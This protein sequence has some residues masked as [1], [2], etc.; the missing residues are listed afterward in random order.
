[1]TGVSTLAV[2]SYG[3]TALLYGAVTLWVLL[4]HRHRPT[5][6]MI[7]LV[8]AATGVWAAAIAILSFAGG[9]PLAAFVALDAFHL[10]AWTA[11]VLSWLD[12]S[13]TKRWLMSGSVLIGIW[14]LAAAASSGRFPS[15]GATAFPALVVAAFIGLLAVEQVSRNAQAPQRKHQRWLWVA[16]GGAFAADIF[17]YSEAMLLETI[18]AWSWDARGIASALLLLPIILAFTSQ[19]AQR[20]L[21]VSRQIVFYTASIVGVGAYVVVMG[22]VAY[23]LRASGGEW[24]VFLQLLFLAAA[25]V[26]LVIVL[27]SSGIRAR[28]RVFVVKHFYRHKYDYREEWLRLTSTLGRVDELPFASANA[29]AGLARIIGSERG[30]LWLERDGQRYEWVVSLENEPPSVVS[31]E[32]T[33]P[34][35]AF[36][37]AFKWIIDSDEYEHEPDRYGTSFGDPRDGVLPLR[38]IVVPL[39]CLGHLQGFA[40]LAK[41]PEW[42]RLNFED[43]DILKTAGRQ[44]AVVLAQALS[45]ERLAETRQFEAMSRLTAFL[46]HD[47]KN[48]VAQQELV[49]ANAQRFR[50]RPE[51]IDDA[52]VTIRSG[53]ERMKKLLEQL[54]APGSERSTRRVD[55]SK[56][57]IEIRSQCADRTPIPEIE[58]HSHPAWVNMDRDRLAN[59]LTHLVRNAQDAT[60]PDGSIKLDV[61]GGESEVVITVADTGCGMDAGFVRD[62][63]FRPFDS[64][65]GAKGMGIGAYQVRHLVRLAGGEV[66]VTSEPGQGTVF[67]LRIPAAEAAY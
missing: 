49:V 52:F 14:A 10:L 30:G 19:G 60:P 53:V 56:V 25:A 26:V 45:H 37:E 64:T 5:A 46:M 4:S 58:V 29:L 24:G 28:L 48:I 33:H 6:A 13:R 16:A 7:V 57:A 61:S 47:L 66:D 51:F 39:D 12:A 20:Q 23:L 55:V 43:H 41:P 18:I 32:R 21:F 27:F 22:V 36:L 2:A 54:N 44:V 9:A 67:R 65:K 15:L 1:M 63:L 35:I 59:A 40:V 38:S 31:Y 8:I 62:R 17:L 42:R 34:M 3:M 50:H 11:C